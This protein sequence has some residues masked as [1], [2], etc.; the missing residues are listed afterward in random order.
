MNARGF[1]AISDLATRHLR[2]IDAEDQFGRLVRLARSIFS[3]PIAILTLFDGTEH[4]LQAESGLEPHQA[5]PDMAF[6]DFVLHNTTPLMIADAR[7][8]T[9]LCRSSS[10]RHAPFIR[11]YCGAPMVDSD[12]VVIGTI[13]VFDYEALGADESQMESLVDLSRIA[14]DELQLKAAKREAEDARRR[15]FDAIE[16][17]PDGFILFDEDDRLAVFNSRML[18]L[19]SESAGSLKIGKTFEEIMRETIA[20]GQYRDA[21]GREE[22]WLQD[23]LT[24]HRNPAGMMEQQTSDGRWLRIYEKKTDTGATVGFRV[25]IT[26]LK[27]REAELFEL[28]TRDSLTGVLTRRAILDDVQREHVR[29]GRYTSCCSVLI[30]DVDHFKGVNDIF[31]HQTGDEAL[32]RI[33]AQAKTTIRE[34][35]SLGRLGGEEFL[36][37]LPDTDLN[38]AMITAERLRLEIA[39]LRIACADRKESVSVTVSIGVAEFRKGENPKSL[40]AR[41][42]QCLYQAKL[43]GRNCVHGDVDE[44]EWS[45]SLMLRG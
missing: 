32:R 16:A 5:M 15:L 12:G 10:V 9:Q 27:L 38:G 36:V 20:T 2:H 8:H 23:R 42:D 19:Y 28:A 37:V 13:G 35:D 45:E 22:E 24:R 33:C 17:L 26:E 21:E 18:E 34:A 7:T 6:C 40:L 39:A 29:L 41:G 31:G 43:N 44:G 11:S 25:D 14:V 1:E 3:A 30:I 4:L